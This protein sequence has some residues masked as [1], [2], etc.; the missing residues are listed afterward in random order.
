[1]FKINLK[2]IFQY[3]QN[4]FRTQTIQ[5]IKIINDQNKK[6]SA[7]THATHHKYYANNTVQFEGDQIDI[8]VRP[9]TLQY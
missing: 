8:Y 1:M 7:F 3:V 2:S 6:E 5:I 4:T 9:T